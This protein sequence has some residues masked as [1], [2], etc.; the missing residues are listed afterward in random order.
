VND[1][2]TYHLLRLLAT[3]TVLAGSTPALAQLGIEAYHN[4][5]AAVSAGRL[6]LFAQ[7]TGTGEDPPC[8][9]LWSDGE[10]R[11][12]RLSDVRAEYSSVI[13]ADG[14]F[15]LFLARTVIELDAESL[16]KTGRVEW[17]FRWPV[18][19]ALVRDGVLMTFGID[20]GR[21]YAASARLAA[22]RA[23]SPAGS[24]EAE[25]RVLSEPWR[26][27]ALELEGQGKCC[28][29]RALLVGGSVWLFWSTGDES[30]CEVLRSGVLEGNV[31]R[32]TAT[33]AAQSGPVGFAVA[34]LDDEPMVVYAT[35]PSRLGEREETR[36]VYRVRGR[37][38]WPSLSEAKAVRNPFGEQTYTL[39]AAT[40]GRRVHLFLGTETRVLGATYDGEVWGPARCVLADAEWSWV[41]EHLLAVRVAGLAA[42][43]VFLVSA[44]RARFRPRR[45]VIG[46][47][48]YSF[49]SWSRRVAAGVCDLCICLVVVAA[50]NALAGHEQLS[51]H[52]LMVALFCVELVYF[53]VLE[54]HAGK[55]VGKRLFGLIVVSRN[56]GY[57]NWSEA[58]RR[59]LPRALLDSL[60]LMMMGVPTLLG[61][62]GGSVLILNT[63]GSQR[64]GDLAA[65]TYVVREPP[66][67]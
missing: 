64:A 27:K 16:T 2:R 30:Q 63:R 15:Y 52:R 60:L 20:G 1:R 45:A 32:D 40:L 17:P 39:S 55:T 26:W 18:Q 29:V 28:S 65:G 50:L 19:T 56:G 35:L 61:W 31:V 37:D 24:D 44:V 49:A 36:L 6:Y 7:L 58:A 11:W 46:G 8:V 14:R 38:G 5:Q 67:H 53:S 4:P 13:Y 66:H 62:L 10:G 23:G 25:G 57:P 9:C 42:V 54:S 51:P 3:A 47:V 41:V 12:H 21:A 34:A 33:L 48:E 59:A 22:R 43:V